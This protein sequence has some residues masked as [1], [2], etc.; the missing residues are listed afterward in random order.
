MV[1]ASTLSSAD[2]NRLTVLM[3]STKA[4]DTDTRES[5]DAPAAS[6]NEGHSGKIVGTL[7]SIFDK[8]SAQL[9]DALKTEAAD[10]HN[11]HTLKLSLVNK[12]KNGNQEMDEGIVMNGE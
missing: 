3:Q 1:Q 7:D 11:F 10:L 9:N 8:A 5:L 12:I 6:I 2:T 4:D